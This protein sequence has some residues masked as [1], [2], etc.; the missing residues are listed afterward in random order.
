[1]NALDLHNLS[2]LLAP[3]RL[4]FGDNLYVLRTHIADASVDLCYIDPPFNSK[5]NYN[6]IYGKVGAED[7][8]QAQ[9]FVDTWL[10]DTIAEQGLSEIFDNEKGRFTSQTIDL[11]QG[12]HN[13][14]GKCSLF[15]YLVSMTLRMTEIHRVLKLTGSFYL[16]CDTT[17]SHYLKLLLDTVFGPERFINEIIWKRTN[18]HSD[19]KRWSPVADTLLFYAK[20]DVF[21]WNPIYIPHDPDYVEDKYRFQEPDGRRYM[22]DNMTSP[23][24]RPNMMYEWKGHKS[25]PLGWRYSKETMAKRKRSPT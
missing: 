16:H 19:A 24:P 8:A 5:R 6:Q 9:A 12:F 20:S 3:N 2:H 1:M 7:R 4:Y 13:I 18:I 14:L 25:P 15:A 11:I 10:W 23:S 22:L 21:T 17:A